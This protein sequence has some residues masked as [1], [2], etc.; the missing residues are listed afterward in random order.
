MYFAFWSRRLKNMKEIDVSYTIKMTDDVFE[1]M[2]EGLGVD[3]D[4]ELIGV[5]KMVVKNSI[6]ASKDIKIDNVKMAFKAEG[7][8][9]N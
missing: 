5:L 9:L 1:D 3:T 4:E 8:D 6:K 2:K 7:T